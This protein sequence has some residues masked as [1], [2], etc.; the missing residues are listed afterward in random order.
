MIAWVSPER[1]VRST[2]RRISLA[3]SPSPT[4]TCRSRI[5]S[6][7][8]LLLAPS[9]A[10]RGGE[11][12]VDRDI[13]VHVLPFHADRVDGHRLGGRQ[14]GGLAGAQVEARP[15]QPAL[16]GGGALELLDVALGQRDLG[17]RAEVLDRVDVTL[18][19]DDGDVDVGQ[20]DPERPGL[21]DVVQRTDALEAH[22]GTSCSSN[23]GRA[24][25][26]ASM[27]PIRRSCSSGRPI[28]WTTSAKKPR[29]TRR[30]AVSASMPREQR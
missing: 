27:V 17:V 18:E 2:P 16:D 23:P 9:V 8:T 25:R 28:S 4:V 24:P 11:A 29:T 30:R 15:V 12:V 26:R 22:A 21:L 10:G 1:T 3:S 5:S 20:L 13:D 19:A 7:D 14:V 6:T